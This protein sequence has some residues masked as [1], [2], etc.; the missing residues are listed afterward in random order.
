MA[1]LAHAIQTFQKGDLSR[2]EFFAQVDRALAAERGNW[3]RLK[4]ILS[5]ENTRGLLPADVYAELQRRV[6]HTPPPPRPET[7]GEETR[8][9]T[10][11]ASPPEQG[12]GVNMA[13][14]GADLDR[15]KG[16]GD[17]LNGR[18]VLEECIGFGGMGTVYKALDLRKLE[19]SDRKPYI[20]IKVLNVQ[21]RGHP[22]SLITLQR[23]AKK[24]QALAHPNIVRVYDFDRDGS[25]V[26]LTMEYLAGKP[27]SQLLRA[28]GFQGMPYMEALRIAEGIGKALA[29]AHQQGFVHCDL[30]PANVFLTERG[31]VKVID[32]GISRAFHKPEDDAEATVFDP[33]SLGG[34]T[35]AYASPEMVEHSDPDPRDDIYGLACITYEMLTGRHPYNRMSGAE[36]RNV[37]MKP[38]RPRQLGHRQWQALK[39]A[40]AFERARRTPSV[41]SFIQGLRGER[42]PAEYMALGVGALACL[43]LIAAGIGYY[44]EFRH[45][46]GNAAETAAVKPAAPEPPTRPPVA[47][48]APVPPAP[49]P[50]L[51]VSAVAPVLSGLPCTALAPAVRGNAVQVQGY[52]ADSIGPA[53]LKDLLEAVPG[54]KS[55]DLRVEQVSQEKCGVL[56]AF[57]P[58]WL[59]NRKSATPATLRA[60]A[61]NAQLVEGEPLVVNITTPAYDGY[62]TVDY[63][64][65]D[66]SVLHMVPSP[67]A[68]ANQ[69]PAN[70]AATIGSMGNWII[71]KPFGTEMIALIVTPAPLFETARP[72]AEPRAAYLAA[73]E[74]RLAQLSAKY[75]RDKVA[76]DLLQVSTR[77]RRP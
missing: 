74:Q 63:Y 35:P 13:M 43:L 75:G 47:A 55:V 57:A 30:K 69:A 2:S 3:Q 53:K 22:K 40:L 14:A 64:V 37:G 48:P 61:P 19:A 51:T 46:P 60:K 28:P 31:E 67:R 42:R 56:K 33:G 65:L 16:V 39:A 17:T 41:E 58:Y 25:V 10:S 45:G 59:N 54:V 24:A 29:Y 50:A 4:E 49:T 36:A 71:S 11:A 62:V 15:M 68:R 5:E 70:Y 52:L 38:E 44:W 72:E 20:A 27:L 26:Y 76:V 77:A 21:F 12:R 6:E 7:E 23:E 9:R 66:G 34:L 32:F 8:V 1:S 73:L 18:F